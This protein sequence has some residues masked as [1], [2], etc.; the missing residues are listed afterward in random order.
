MKS[1]ILELLVRGI[2]SKRY[3]RLDYR[4]RSGTERTHELGPH[5]LFPHNG[6]LYLRGQF[7]KRAGLTTF[8]VHGIQRVELLDGTFE[9]IRFRPTAFGVYEEK[10]R[11]VE[12]HF[13]AALAPIIAERVWHPSQKLRIRRDG[14]LVLT[15][16]LGGRYEFIGWV[17]SWGSGANLV[18]PAEW[19]EELA[20]HVR[21]LGEQYGV[22]QSGR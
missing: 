5:H 8:L 7:P 15:A 17:L 21:E 22:T 16:R 18:R 2:L 12:A 6:V 20:D 4:T 14:S 13:N 3:C 9:P 10:A 19:R 1:E 11:A